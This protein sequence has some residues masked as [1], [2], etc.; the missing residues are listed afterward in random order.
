QEFDRVLPSNIEHECHFRLYGRSVRKVLLRPYAEIDAARLRHLRKYRKNVLNRLFVRNEVLEGIVAS[1][2]REIG[3]HAPKLGIGEL[4][5]EAVRL[6]QN[7]DR[8]Y[9]ESQHQSGCR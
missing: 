3:E 9:K 1:G 8:G 6:G 5:R 2:L 7:R 4:C